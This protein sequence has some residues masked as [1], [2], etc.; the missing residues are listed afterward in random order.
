[1][2]FKKQKR[3][4]NIAYQIAAAT[5]VHGSPDGS[6]PSNW[7]SPL[8]TKLYM[9]W[10]SGEMS[11]SAVQEIAHAAVQ[12]GITSAEVAKLAA[13][14]CW[15]AYP[16]NCKRDLV[17]YL[18]CEWVPE[19]HPVTVPC[20]DTRPHPALV[21]ET[22]MAVFLP[23]EWLAAIGERPEAEELLGLDSV[24]SFWQHVN[25]QDPRLLAEGGHPVLARND[26]KS[27]CVPLWLHGDGV[28][29]SESD[30]LMVFSF[31]S[32]LPSTTSMCSMFLIAGFVKSVTAFLK[33]HGRCTWT[34]AWQVLAWSFM[35]CWRGTWP[36]TDYKGNAYNAGSKEALNA[37]KPLV[38]GY[39]FVIWNIIGDLEFMANTMNLPHWGNLNPCWHCNC[40]K[41]EGARYRYC[42]AAGLRGWDMHDPIHY[43]HQSEHPVFGLPGVTSWAVCFDV[44]H[45]L[46]THGLAS[47][48]AGA[49]LHQIVYELAGTGQF[50]ANEAMA[51]IWSQV[52]ELYDEN[53]TS[54][55]F[56]HM[57]LKMICDP[58]KPNAAYVTLK[59]KAGKTRHLIPILLKVAQAYHNGTAVSSHRIA[60]L[61]ALTA[62]YK[63][64]DTQPMFMS[65]AAS[66]EAM[67]QMESL[68]LH[69]NWLHEQGKYNSKWYCNLVAKYHYCWHLAYSCRFM[70]PRYTWS[71]KA[72][73]WVGKISHIASSCA[74][75]VN[76][77]RITNPLAEKYRYFVHVRLA[78]QVFE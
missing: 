51:Q 3:A 72:E 78:R 34:E 75:G 22:E 12:D 16:G 53:F 8:A 45:C 38:S 71:Y 26:Y 15:G 1:M 11:A 7:Q 47:H 67:S 40:E 61:K 39:F 76:A 17:S 48:L 14:G 57:L 73:S 19:P 9:L 44:L 43:S 32:I 58:K 66:D 18:S 27:K 10:T 28:E 21:V 23:H 52:L 62:F 50:T 74:F 42:I 77:A 64:L 65:T 20:L 46:D 31:G 63:L 33:I 68:L 37:G 35:A 4:F 70:N 2:G 25:P 30:S 54:E 36:S 59:A 49:V 5:A 13:F 60:A 24:K 29:Y 56:S 69:Y 41:N 55:R 6:K